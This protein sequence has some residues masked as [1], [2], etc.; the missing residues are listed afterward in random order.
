MQQ[1]ISTENRPDL[2]LN[3]KEDVLENTER[4]QK[5]VSSDDSLSQ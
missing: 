4:R 2:L 5:L 1:L 3:V